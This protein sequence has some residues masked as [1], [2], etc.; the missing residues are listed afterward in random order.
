MICQL[1][2]EPHVA[3]Y[4][5]LTLGHLGWRLLKNMA[6]DAAPGEVDSQHQTYWPSPNQKHIDHLCLSHSYLLPF[7]ALGLTEEAFFTGTWTLAASARA[8]PVEKLTRF[9]AGR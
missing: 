5:N 1:E 7:L 2:R 4:K 9:P 3:S 6:G 8:D